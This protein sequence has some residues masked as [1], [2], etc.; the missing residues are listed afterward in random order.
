MEKIIMGCAGNGDMFRGWIVEMFLHHRST[1]DPIARAL[2]AS[3]GAFWAVA[4]FSAVVNILGLTGSFY[5]LQIYDR[6]LASRSIATLV[7]LSVL[8][9]GLFALQ[10]ALEIIR[11]Q[12]LSRVAARIERDLLKPVHDL[13]LRL[14]LLGLSAAEAVQP[15]RDMEAV[16]MF[17]ASTAPLAFLDLPWMPLYL[18]FIFLL[19]PWL[20]FL[21]VAG[22]VVLALLTVLT[23]ARL[24][25][26]NRD[27]TAAAARRQQAVETSRRN[28]EV[29]RAMGF[30]DRAAQRFYRASGDLF[31]ANQR[32]A[33]VAG[34]LGSV[35][36]VFRIILQSAT[37]GLGAFLVLK[38]Q[39]SAGA[40]IAS[41][42]L[43]GRAL[44]PVEMVI[45]NWKLFVA[46]RQARARL[47]E[48]VRRLGPSTA[49]VTLPIA[50]STLAVE[51]LVIG[52]P[53]ARHPI[54]RNLRFFLKAGDGL[55]ILGPSGAG[56]ST[57]VRALVG[58][59]LPLSGVIRFDGAPLDQWPAESIGKLIGYLPQDVELFDGTVAE[60]I[61]RLD[62]EADHADIVAAAQAA[63]VHDL[64][65]RL[66][67][68]YATLLGEGG[69][70]LSIGQRQRIGLARALYGVPFLVVLDEPN[71]HLDE[72]GEV[73][74]S[75]AIAGIRE[76]GGI[77]IVVSHRRGIL[78]NVNAVALVADGELKA[79]GPRDEVLTR[80]SAR[81]E[82]ARTRGSAPILPMQ[83]G[84]ALPGRKSSI[85]P[86]AVAPAPPAT[87]KPAEPIPPRERTAP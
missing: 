86:R 43:S 3:R 75:R 53:G 44:A 11:G 12:V 68:G 59:W 83:A 87:D 41:S 60:N 31:T 40:I 55:A 81:Q 15:V 45:A 35:S 64:I 19:H 84:V 85:G 2:A 52:A 34:T 56:K 73:A 27:A 24:R 10:G 63:R 26:P 72:E 69:Q 20:G 46:A 9:L 61:A 67:D 30:A 4:V 76:R 74:L 39:M 38:G 82:G 16:R 18:G 57:L 14:P 1:P 48:A 49:R 5:M 66:P 47:Q 32:I 21:S 62:P 33:D 50:R 79:F 58:A 37:L 8:A 29:L 13:V 28:I 6:V 42:I 80:L 70:N 25:Q 65:L 78:A 7:A 54:V 77:V 51:N 36:R 23:E 22:M 71:A 17:T